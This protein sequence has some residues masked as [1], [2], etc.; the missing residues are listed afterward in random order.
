[1]KNEI[2]RG[3]LKQAGEENG[4]RVQRE[5]KPREHPC[6][7]RKQPPCGK[8][9][10]HARRSAEERLSDAYRQQAAAG[11]RIDDADEIRVERRLVKHLAAEPAAG[12]DLRSPCVVSSGVADEHVEER[13]MADLENV[14]E[15]GHERDAGNSPE[16]PDESSR[17]RRD[18]YV[19]SRAGVRA[20][21]SH[22]PAGHERILSR[23]R[24]RISLGPRATNPGSVAFVKSNHQTS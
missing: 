14:D 23:G 24:H 2:E 3:F 19:G 11:Y 20:T 21:R 6:A 13:R 1:M 18:F 22:T 12:G 15:A 9:Q 10:E 17:S 5:A 8:R 16:I 7:L 4:G